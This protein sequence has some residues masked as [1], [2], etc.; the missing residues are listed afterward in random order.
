MTSRNMDTSF[1]QNWLQMQ[2]CGT[3]DTEFGDVHFKSVK[4][5]PH[6]TSETEQQFERVGLSGWITAEEN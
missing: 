6:N 5:I 3:V 2:L 4:W 1:A